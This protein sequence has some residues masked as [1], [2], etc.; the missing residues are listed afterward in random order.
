MAVVTV[1]MVVRV[2]RV[3]RPASVGP[4]DPSPHCIEARRV[5]WQQ[6]LSVL[7]GYNYIGIVSFLH[8]HQY[9]LLTALLFIRKITAQLGSVSGSRDSRD[10]PGKYQILFTSITKYILFKEKCSLLQC[11]LWKLFIIQHFFL[12]KSSKC[13]EKELIEW[14][15]FFC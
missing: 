14:K 15:I 12:L 11:F 9:T 2:V 3:V 6:L 7:M 5:A 4:C 8:Y 10:L 13:R 1:V